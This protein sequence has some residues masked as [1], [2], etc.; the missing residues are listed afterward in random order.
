MQ[1]TSEKSILKTIGNVVSAI[2]CVILSLILILNC[3][4][5]VKGMVKSDKVPSIFG[6]YPMIVLSDS[7]FPEI[8][9]GD[10][11]IG[12]EAKVEELKVGDT[13]SFFDPESKTGAVVTHRITDIEVVDGQTLITTKGDANS[14]KDT[15]KV[16]GDKVIGIY[17]SKI[18][19]AGKVA[20]FMQTTTGFIVCIAVPVVLLVGYDFIT[21]RKKPEEKA[22]DEEKEKLLAELEALR[23]EKAKLEEKS[24]GSDTKTEEK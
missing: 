15:E 21:K 10:L 17:Q 7:M 2:I 24:V 23:A 12:K 20:M 13:I 1:K 14:I 9:K 18:P 19:G 22:A 5:I 4:L 16:P 11:I 6:Y 3:T 8:K